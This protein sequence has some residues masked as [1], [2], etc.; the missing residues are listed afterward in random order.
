[1]AVGPVGQ[2]AH[3]LPDIGDPDAG[4][5]D[6]GILPLADIGEGPCSIAEQ[7]YSSLNLTPLQTKRVLGMTQLGVTGHQGHRVGQ[8]GGQGGRVRQQS[9]AEQESKSDVSAR[10]SGTWFH[11][12][13]SSPYRFRQLFHGDG[14]YSAVPLQGAYVPA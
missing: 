9:M 3:G 8:V 7:R 12:L 2:E 4:Q 14:A 10:S 13:S 5:G 11:A 6:G 1:M